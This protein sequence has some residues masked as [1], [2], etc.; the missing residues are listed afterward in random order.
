MRSLIVALVLG[1]LMAFAGGCV[2]RAHHPGPVVATVRAPAPV[3][4]VKKPRPYKCYRTGCVRRCNIW[5][6]WDKCRRI[7]YRCYR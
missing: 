2:V 3:V 1:T 5:G 7:A 4:V 6:C